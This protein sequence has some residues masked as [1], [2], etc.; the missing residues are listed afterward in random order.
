MN[1]IWLMRAASITQVATRATSLAAE[2]DQVR[3]AAR[4]RRRRR[5]QTRQADNQTEMLVVMFG[6]RPSDGRQPVNVLTELVGRLRGRHCHGPA[7]RRT[8]WRPERAVVAFCCCCFRP[9]N[10]LVHRGRRRRRR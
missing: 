2:V 5:R 9:S 7:G 6:G 1:L 10:Q 8:G 3:G 4:R